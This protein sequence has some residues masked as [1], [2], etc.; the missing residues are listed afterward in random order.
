MPLGH[1]AIQHGIVDF[2]LA[3]DDFTHAS[4]AQYGV[5]ACFG[6]DNSGMARICGHGVRISRVTMITLWFA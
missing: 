5:F 3:F 6:A 1:L 2:V 4:L